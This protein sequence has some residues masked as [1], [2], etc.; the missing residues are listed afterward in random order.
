K[1][2]D[3]PKPKDEK[4]KDEKGKE[5]EEQLDMRQGQLEP[6]PPV[7]L[8]AEATMACEDHSRYL[9]R[10]P[11]Q[12]MKWPEAHEENPALEGFS[13][14]G[15]RAGMRSV[16]VFLHADGGVDFAKESVDGW[17]GTVYHRFPL[18]EHNINRFGYSYIFE[19][20]WSVATLD[21]GSL[22]EPYDPQRAPKF[23]CWPA[24]GMKEV[25][26]GFDGNEMPNPLDDQPESERD[27]RNV[28][29]PVSLQLQSGFARTR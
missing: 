10:Y 12:H 14:R 2:K 4:G 20:G 22:E 13:P 28:G 5:K 24:P 18:L 17:I 7:D 1:D 26:L 27:L 21:M 3:K 19:N 8:D 25:P 15:M 11:E 6:L 9:T 29:S 16:I 23:V